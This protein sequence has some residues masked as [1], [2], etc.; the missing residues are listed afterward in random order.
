MTHTRISIPKLDQKHS[1]TRI[2]GQPWSAR[3][4]LKKL[5]VPS[6]VCWR[7]CQWKQFTSIDCMAS[8]L[9]V[10]NRE[11][12]D[13]FLHD[14]LGWCGKTGHQRN[15]WHG[16]GI[17][18]HQLF[19]FLTSEK[20]LS[21]ENGVPNLSG[22]R[23]VVAN[24]WHSSWGK[25]LK[26]PWWPHQSGLVSSSRSVKI[27]PMTPFR[28][29]SSTRLNW[30]P[31]KCSQLQQ[32]CAE[33]SIARILRDSLQNVCFVKLNGNVTGTSNCCHDYACFIDL[34]N[35]SQTKL[36]SIFGNVRN[37]SLGMLKPKT[38]SQNLLWWICS[39][40]GRIFHA[41]LPSSSPGDISTPEI[42]K[43]LQAFMGL[44]YLS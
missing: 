31:Y 20:E 9:R 21:G 43:T 38:L 32:V 4:L 7:L 3:M 40:Q 5:P 18:I 10:E 34:F 6:Q 23:K 25:T 15:A 11:S 30:D 33:G 44:S 37:P 26:N 19:S 22:P 27:S 17:F 14:L 8:S 13:R 35:K 16:W 28:S 36:M 1:K 2:W 39:C 12:C 41:S 29:H 24:P 42:E